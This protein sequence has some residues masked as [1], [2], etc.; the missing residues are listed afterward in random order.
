MSTPMTTIQRDGT[1][2][3]RHVVRVLILARSP[4]V[5]AGLA[6]LL[7]TDESIV[8]AQPPVIA[9]GW[10]RP[11]EGNPPRAE[12]AA[13]PDVVVI[14]RDSLGAEAVDT[15]TERHSGTPMVLLGGDDTA[16]I[17]LGECPVAY[18]GPDADGASLIASVHAVLAGL[19]VI[20]PAMAVRLGGS[21]SIPVT[22]EP[23]EALTPREQ[24]VLR[25]VSEGLPN[26]TIARELGISEHTAKFHVGS[27]LAKL[28][29]GSRTEAVMTATRRG[30]LTV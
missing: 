5:R 24:E 22:L 13:Q 28:H 17:R 3:T 6:A 20:E 16:P 2:T 25:L 12:S 26:K 8:I 27:L 15:A 23:G 1:T 21:G 10:L 11:G 19:T 9:G 7:T 29:A 30:L 14:D 4:A 18:L